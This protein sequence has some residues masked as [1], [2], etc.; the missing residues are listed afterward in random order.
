MNDPRLNSAHFEDFPRRQDYRRAR[1][2][3]LGARG[4]MT[5][6]VER[7]HGM[8]E[9]SDAW[10]DLLPVRPEHV[11]PGTKCWLIEEQKGRR[12][13]LQ[14]G[15]NTVG[16]FSEN[17]IVLEPLSV[18]RRHCALLVHVW[19]GCELYDTA[20]R[21]GTFVNGDRIQQ[22]RRLQSGDRIQIG[23][24]Q[25]RFF[26]ESDCP[27]DDADPDYPATAILG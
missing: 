4:W 18:S 15:L 23:P 13:A 17:D 16:R 22:S 1:E 11:L 12:Y 9:D 14:T 2:A 24:V 27:A 21:N 10:P 25:L 5:L 7:V 20:S 3:L 26:H 8:V 19:G 6:A